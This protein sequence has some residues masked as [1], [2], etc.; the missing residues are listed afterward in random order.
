MRQT[1]RFNFN[2]MAKGRFVPIFLLGFFIFFAPSSGLLAQPP[3]KELPM[4]VTLNDLKTEPNQYDGHRIVVT[5]RVQSIELQQGRRGS[6]YVM[7]VLEEELANPS[8]TRPTIK[9]VSLTLP[10]V[11]QGHFALVQG[12]Y[13]VEGRQAGRPFEH[14]IDAEVI[15]KEKL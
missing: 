1:C 8:S 6:E 5:G 12:T 14:F 7:L 15:L 9:V 13:H 4:L 2:L 11:K 3:V 10:T